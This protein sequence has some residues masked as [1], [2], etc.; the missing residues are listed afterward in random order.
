MHKRWFLGMVLALAVSQSALGEGKKSNAPQICAA[1]VRADM[2][3]LASDELHGRGS[4][5][6]DEHLAALYAAAQFQALGLEPGGD[7]G[8]FLQKAA[9]PDPLPP[10]VQQRLSKYEDASRKETWNAVA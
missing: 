8:T 9:L 3:F 2:N 5:T 1:C 10:R 7:G 4:A 6:R